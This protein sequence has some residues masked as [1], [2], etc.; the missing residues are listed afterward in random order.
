MAKAAKKKA[1]TGKKAV[2][3]VAKSKAATISA[4][5]AKKAA[6]P[7]RKVARKKAPKIDPLNR[8]QYS[9]MTPML[10]VRDVRR[11]ADFYTSAFGFK[12][13]GIMD[14]PQGPVH[15]ELRLRD[16]TLMLSPESRAQQSLSAN[17]IGNTPATLYILVEDVDDVFHRALAAGA[18]VLMP[19]GDMFWGDRVAT[20][21][22]LDGNKW[23]IATHK[24]TPTEAEMR[25]AMARMSAPSEETAAV[26]A[27][28]ESE[29]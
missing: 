5:S 9:S 27:G 15:A 18:K 14:S 21:A 2:R 4:K 24:A 28:A 23:M 19:V 10:T 25:E 16:T 20:I 3:V 13:R 8:N 26:T 1:K 7:T 29:Y 6:K 22:D 17:T 12:I 11:A